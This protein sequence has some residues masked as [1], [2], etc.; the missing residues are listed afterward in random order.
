MYKDLEHLLQDRLKFNTN[1]IENHS[2][3]LINQSLTIAEQIKN[4][5][6]N[7]GKVILFGNGGSHA[8]SSHLSTE[9]LIRFKRDSLRLP[10]PAFAISSDSSVITACGNDFNFKYI[11][12][13]QLESILNE[14][15][16]IIAFSTSGKSGN[17]IEAINFAKSILNKNKIF[18]I[19]GNLKYSKLDESISIIKTPI[20]GNTETYQE[21][22]LLLIHMVCNVLEKTYV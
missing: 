21:F 8:Q 11:Y 9:L 22:H 14:N 17:I 3:T 10:I 19:T 7:K 4:T 2:E 15:D 20:A 6:L 5:A 16:C 12:K 18:L 1:L 13:K